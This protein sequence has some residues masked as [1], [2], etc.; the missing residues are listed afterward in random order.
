MPNSKLVVKEPSPEE[1]AYLENSINNSNIKLTGIPFGGE[2]AVL[3]YDE[4]DKRVG[5]VS[6]FQWGDALTVEYLWLEE[7]WRGQDLGTQLLCSIENQ[8]AARGCTQSYLDTYNFQALGFYQKLGYE[9]VGTLENFPTPYTHYFL[10]KNL[11][12]S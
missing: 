9:V 7:E 5:G 3:V 4:R 10:K 11:P 2:L 12:V 8:A 1:R 6:G